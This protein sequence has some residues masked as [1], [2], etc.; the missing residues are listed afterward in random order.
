[1]DEILIEVETDKVVMEVP[2]PSGGSHWSNSLA[3]DG[4][5]VAAEQLIAR[6]DTEG[7]PVRPWRL[8]WRHHVSCGGC[9]CC[10]PPVGAAASN[11]Q[12]RCGHARGSQADGRQQPVRKARWPVPA[13]MAA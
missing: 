3:A 4:S 11:E 5:T 12:S 10:G 1:V 8:P 6:I 9:V 2:A 13:K 7:W